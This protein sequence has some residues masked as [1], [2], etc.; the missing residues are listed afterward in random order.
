M[1]VISQIEMQLTYTAFKSPAGDCTGCEGEAYLD[2]L[3]SGLRKI[4]SLPAWL[5]KMMLLN[6]IFLG[7]KKS[8][9]ALMKLKTERK[10]KS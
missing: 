5:A 7:R 6:C 8:L 9:N 2:V 4:S 1:K 10:S 3:G